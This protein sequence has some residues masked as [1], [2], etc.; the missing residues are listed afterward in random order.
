[1]RVFCAH[2]VGPRRDRDRSGASP[3]LRT[4]PAYR[5][6]SPR[7]PMRT[8]VITFDTRARQRFYSLAQ[9]TAYHARPG[10]ARRI[11]VLV[12]AVE[13]GQ[14]TVRDGHAALAS[15]RRDQQQAA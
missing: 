5:R 15:L 6:R 4:D 7:C 2:A 8:S 10:E 11:D 1:M 9:Q 3:A 13:A 12:A 14:V